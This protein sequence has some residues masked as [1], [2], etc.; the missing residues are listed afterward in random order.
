MISRAIALEWATVGWTAVVA[1]VGIAAGVVARSVSLTAFGLDGAVECICA[2]I[3]LRRL[4]VEAAHSHDFDAR[5]ERQA[6]RAVGALLLVAAAYVTVDALIHLARHQAQSVTTIAFVLT[7]VSIPILIPLSVAKLKLARELNSIALHVDAIGNV[8]CLYLAIVVLFGLLASA[9]FHLW[10]FDGAASLLIVTLLI[11]EGTG[12][13][14][15]SAA[16]TA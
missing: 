9:A 16:P 7:V 10:W 11:K 12:A 2:V 3:V 5:Y 15:E 4:L 1:F 6:A 14:R 8:V 13:I